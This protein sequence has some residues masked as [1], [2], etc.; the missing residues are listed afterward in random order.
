MDDSLDSVETTED[1][2]QL[3]KDLTKIWE[4]A[5]MKARKWLSNDPEVLKQIPIAKRSGQVDLSNI[6]QLLPQTKTLGVI[7]DAE[8]DFFTFTVSEVENRR[9]TK[10]SFLKLIASIFDPLGFLSSFIIRAKVLMQ[11]LW[12]K[13][14]DW[15]EEIDEE[16]SKDIE[17][18]V[19]ELPTINSV[20]VPRCL[21]ANNCQDN[22]TQ[23]HIFIDTSEYAL[24]VVAYL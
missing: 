22:H 17:N 16:T 15:D 7:W 10:R 13:Q 3:Y 11:T 6:Y 23:I 21:A 2:I 4:N 18:W 20:M 19:S 24:A 12:I 8:G 14:T 1:A 5:G 9:F